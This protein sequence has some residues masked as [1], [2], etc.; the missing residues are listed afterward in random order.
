[1]LCYPKFL[2]FAKAFSKYFNKMSKAIPL[3]GKVFIKNIN[4]KL[5]SKKKIKLFVIYGFIT[6]KVTRSLR[7]F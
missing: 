4:I 6:C 2:R 5:F 1:M 3:R 7:S